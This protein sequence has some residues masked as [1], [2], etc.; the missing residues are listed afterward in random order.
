V[1]F[2]ARALKLNAGLLIVSTVRSAGSAGPT[3]VVDGGGISI[4][5]PVFLKDLTSRYALKQPG[6]CHESGGICSDVD[7]LS[8]L[9][10]LHRGRSM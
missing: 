9:G 5:H 1:R 3:V 2:N 10:T 6:S 4:S 7:E 8:F